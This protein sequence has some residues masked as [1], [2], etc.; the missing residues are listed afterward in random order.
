MSLICFQVVRVEAI[1]ERCFEILPKDV[2]SCF[3]G[4]L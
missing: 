2:F 3:E 1:I 4:F